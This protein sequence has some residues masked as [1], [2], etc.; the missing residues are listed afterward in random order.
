MAQNSKTW[1]QRCCLFFIE[2][3]TKVEPLLKQQLFPSQN[4]YL[5]KISS[6]SPNITSY[7]HRLATHTTTSIKQN[8]FLEFSEY[9]YARHTVNACS[10]TPRNPVPSLSVPPPPT[11][12]P[13]SYNWVSDSS[14]SWPNL[15]FSFCNSNVFGLVGFCLQRGRNSEIE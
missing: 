7:V 9:S 15:K 12:V 13:H 2:S 1:T 14:S 8:I 10:I 3:H 4:S 11:V 5:Q 6:T